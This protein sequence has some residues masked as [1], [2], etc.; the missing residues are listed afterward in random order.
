[1]SL[2]RVPRGADAEVCP[3]SLDLGDK[4]LLLNQQKYWYT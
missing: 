2:S 1:M 3:I 4:I